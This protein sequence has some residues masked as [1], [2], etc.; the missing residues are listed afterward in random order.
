MYV[1]QVPKP[2][3]Y[4]VLQVCVYFSCYCLVQYNYY[5]H[6]GVLSLPRVSSRIK[7]LGGRFGRA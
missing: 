3:I 1:Y 5:I 6:V 2:Y 4:I 7:S